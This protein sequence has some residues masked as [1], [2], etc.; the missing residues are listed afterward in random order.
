MVWLN[1][2]HS[3]NKTIQIEKQQPGSSTNACCFFKVQL[4]IIFRQILFSEYPKLL[5]P[6]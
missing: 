2:Q 4:K 3:K 6:G 5:L 1:Q